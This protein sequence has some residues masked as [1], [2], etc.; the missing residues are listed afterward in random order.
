MLLSEIESWDVAALKTVATE[1]G[2]ELE[3]AQRAATELGNLAGLPGWESP[4]A[5]VA[6]ERIATARAHVLDDA[7]V[8]GAVERLAEETAQAVSTLQQQLTALRAEVAGSEGHLSLSDGGEVTI[9]GTAEEIRDLQDEA[10]DIEARAKALIR[11]ADDIDADCAEVFTNIADGKV[12]G[13]RATDFEGA[14]QAGG[15]Q[16]GLSAPYPPDGPG[17]TPHEVTAWWD[18]LS[19]EEQ[20]K[21]VEEH[22]DWIGN[23]DGVPVPPRHDANIDALEREIAAARAEVASIPSRE[24]Y[25]RDH[26]G[27]N[28]AALNSGYTA[29]VG[30]RR[31]R[32]DEALGVQRALSVDGDPGQ[33]YD[34]DRYLMMFEP[35]DTELLAAVAIGNPDEAQHVAVTTPGMT[36]HATSLPSMADEAVALRREAELQLERAGF[37][38]ERVAA[39]AWFGY[40]PPDVDGTVG[41]AVL[42]NRA[43]AG[44][45]DLADFYRGINAT[46]AHGSEV[47][48]S[49][50]GHSYGSTTTA[51]ALNEL[52]ETGVVDDAVFYGSPGLGYANETILGMPALIVDES[53]LFLPDG[54]AFVMSADRDPVSEEVSKWGIDLPVSIADLGAHGPNPTSLPFERLATDASEP[55]YGPPREGASG[56]SEYPRLGSNAVLRTPGYN[57]AIVAAGLAD[58]RPELLIREEG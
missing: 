29:M 53:Q 24:E 18:A 26:P 10:D 56:H 15:L 51:Q 47:H 6:R 39:V 4:A 58:R 37:G 2:A 35:T 3:A 36:T 34:K 55:T 31:R 42:E 20:R 22:P 43:N 46:N 19:P 9:S 7:A 27:R 38:G 16:S 11:Q 8:L 49:A 41:G 48:L 30:D 33:G 40:D 23:R 12:T 1:L 5:D 32:L 21:V 17:V 28:A 52:G 45:V 44:A 14:R 50:L 54:H 57:L 13:G 25:R